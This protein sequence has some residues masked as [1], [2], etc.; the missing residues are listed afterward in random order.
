MANRDVN[1]NI[2]YNVDSAQ[3]TRAEQLLRQAQAASNNFQQSAGNA[4]KATAQ[5]FNQATRSIASM[6]MALAQLKTRI[7]LATDPKKVHQLSQ[8]YRNLKTQIDAATKSAFELPKAI[9]QGEAATKSFTSQLGNMYNAFKLVFAAGAIREVVSFTLE[10]ARL[11]GTVEGVERAFNKLPNA[12]LVIMDLRNAT[13]GAVNDLELMQKALLA[14]NYGISLQALPK[15]LEFAA[16]RAQ[17]TGKSVD[18]LVNSIVDGIGRKSLRVLDNLQLST[19]EIKSELG[20]IS[21]EAASVAQVSEAMGR[22]AS[23]ELEKMGGF[24]ETAAT[25]VSELEVSYHELRVEVSKKIESGGLIDFFN[26]ALLGLKN[27]V[28]A[29]D[30]DITKIPENIR[31]LEKEQERQAQVFDNLKQIQKDEPKNAQ[32]RIDFIQQEINTRVQLIG[33]YN[34]QIKALKAFTLE[35]ITSRR[36]QLEQELG[37]PFDAEDAV[38]KEIKG[39]AKTREAWQQN[40]LVIQ[41]TIDALSQYLNEIQKV[42]AA[43]NIIDLGLIESLQEKIEGLNESIVKAKTPEEIQRLNKEL[44]ITESQLR[45]LKELGSTFGDPLV[46]AASAIKQDVGKIKLKA[47]EIDDSETERL[48]KEIAKKQGETF[49][50]ELNDSIEISSA[51][52]RA[53]F[54]AREELIT[55]GIDIFANTLMMSQDMEIESY[56]I[57]MQNLRDYYDEQQM[58]AGDNEKAKKEIALREEKETSRLRRQIAERERRARIFSIVVDTAA[59]IAK[60]AA[61]LG[62]PAAIPFIALAAANG[63]AQ[64]A[65]ASRAQPQG[66]KDGVINLQGPGTGTSDS[67]PAN[68][69]KGESVMTAKETKGSM[70][71]LKEVRAKTLDDK[72]LESLKL[73]SSGVQVVGMNDRNIVKSINDLKNSIPDVEARGNLLYTTRRK[74][75][76]YKQWVRKSSMSE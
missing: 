26:N 64:L 37:N 22:I 70:K 32:E 20:G 56:Q 36:K 67:I 9:K 1:I 76:N 27:F 68:L 44:R 15:L 57:R 38:I 73:T 5:G 43:E 13:H 62:F 59:S 46:L 24:A 12:E 65:L 23:R 49:N 47:P 28:K 19:T 60:T 41:E 53:F 30:S 6:Q 42:D 25:K 72:V 48:I 31:K 40:K 69:S 10:M 58:L 45:E 33:R 50:K 75:E 39:R 8:E 18:Y 66:F 11:S 55:G 14:Q 52:E 71:I 2:K 54:E 21:M 63:A 3:V 34:D 16:V 4:S 61:N 51:L 17:Q 74:S 35:E 7:E 29:Y